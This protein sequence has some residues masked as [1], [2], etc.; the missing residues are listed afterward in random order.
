M[1]RVV[2]RQR[3]VSWDAFD[4]SQGDDLDI[5]EFSS[6]HGSGEAVVIPAEVP[7]IGRKRSRHSEPPTLI[8]RFFWEIETTLGSMCQD[9]QLHILSFLDE[10]SLRSLAS[11]SLSF[12]SM[13]LSTRGAVEV[14]WTPH[15]E[16]NWNV[17]VTDKSFSKLQESMGLPTAAMTRNNVPNIPLL[18]SMTPSALPTQVDVTLL[19]HKKSLLNP[20]SRRATRQLMEAPESTSTHLRLLEGT[21][22]VVTY[23]GTIGRGDRCVRANNP[24]PRPTNRNVSRW[25]GCQN[26]ALLQS[27]RALPMPPHGVPLVPGTLLNLLRYGTRNI[28]G[29]MEHMRPF[30]A[31]YYQKDGSLNVTPRM[32]AYFEVDILERGDTKAGE[33]EG[34]DEA[35]VPQTTNASECVAVGVATEAFRLHSRM[36]G[37][38]S[39]S[40]GYHGDD[41]GTFHGSGGMNARFGPTFGAGDTV[42]CGIDYVARGI[43]YTLNGAFL[44]YGWKNLK[45]ELLNND[46]YPVVGID[47]NSPIQVNFGIS[48]PFLY[49]LDEFHASHAGFIEP[50]YRFSIPSE[51]RS[52]LMKRQGSL[53]SV[54]SSSSSGSRFLRRRSSSIKSTMS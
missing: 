10:P 19:D 18:L 11:C 40:F 32:V 8:P 3:L 12:R 43:F 47:T 6:H 22:T 50:H 5:S 1:R 2:S 49:N 37:W 28:R 20:T 48:K 13:I 41:G 17:E 44:G 46:L 38:D 21:T 14:I 15:L 24:L 36:P 39:L 53:L 4:A 7:L 29:G 52:G 16:R 30:C 26:A 34:D 25:G 27:Y 51:K 45:P 54:S 23:S 9:A 42:G 33:E 35:T 31:P